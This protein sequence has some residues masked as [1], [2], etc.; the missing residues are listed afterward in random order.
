MQTEA[1]Q[2]AQHIYPELNEGETHLCAVLNEDG[3]TTHTILTP[4]TKADINWQDAMDWAKELGGDLPTRA[5]S[6]LLYENYKDQFEEAWYWTNTQHAEYSGY[7]WY[8]S[9]NGGVQLSWGKSTQ[10]GAR[11]VRRLVI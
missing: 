4:H 6:I 10:L 5:E 3:T 9:F 8:Q 7:A 2:T 11:A 1:Q